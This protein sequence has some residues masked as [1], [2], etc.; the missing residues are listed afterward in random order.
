[1]RP[2]LASEIEACQG[3]PKACVT[4]LKDD[5]HPDG[6]LQVVDLKTSRTESYNLDVCYG[7]TVQSDEIFRNDLEPMLPSLFRGY[8]ATVFT[9][10]ATGSGK[11]Y[12][13]L[14]TPVRPGLMSLAMTS[15][16]GS[17]RKVDC[18]VKISY[19]EV[20][21][22]RCYDLLQSKTEVSVLED[23]SG[24]IQLRGLTQVEVTTVEEFKAKL[25]EGCAR[26]KVGQTGLNDASSRSHGVLM[27][28]V[29]CNSDGT[30]TTG[31]LN[32]IDLAGNEDNR[33]SGNEG[34]R[35][36]ESTKINASLFALSN[37]I[38]ALNANELRVPY[39]DSKLTRILQDSLG[40]TS[41]AVMIACLNPGSYQEASQT[42]SMAARSRQVVNSSSI[43]ADGENDVFEVKEKQNM[44]AKLAAWWETKGKS[45]PAR[46]PHVPSPLRG[47]I[48]CPSPDKSRMALSD[49]SPN[50]RPSF[51]SEVPQCDAKVDKRCDL[52]Q[53][54]AES[55]VENE[56]SRST[57][58]LKVFQD[59]HCGTT[60]QGKHEQTPVREFKGQEA[61][62]E[63]M[64]RNSNDWATPAKLLSNFST[65]P[66]LSTRLRD[67]RN[68]LMS[69]RPLST[70]KPEST[71]CS[72]PNDSL[73]VSSSL[74]YTTDSTMSPT[75]KK[76]PLFSTTP[77][78]DWEMSS[79]GCEDTLLE[80]FLQ[81]LNTACRDE[82]MALKGIGEKRA[83]RLID[84]RKETNEP[85]R[86]LEDL[87]NIGLSVK[88]ARKLFISN[89]TK[90]LEANTA[91]NS[92]I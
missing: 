43:I 70:L 32:I 37:V 34:V 12:T 19:Y 88:Q 73:V 39:R 41:R 15:I 66:P 11:T 80:N 79:R 13:I 90:K 42:L 71:F 69:P 1:M 16:L 9:Y 18:S 10:G 51:K 33:R 91:F 22:D 49:S 57:D 68:S 29:T 48:N 21:M 44:E 61:N 77:M 31:K 36:L 52:A 56:Q 64:D 17:A 25:A 47:K 86:K 55:I 84:L 23:P 54:G 85:I 81:V 78:E 75:I 46:S 2:F 65:S 4:V 50:K 58:I 63:N 76:N 40:G 26:R 92:V 35:L 8:N 74:D 60:A 3:S 83:G 38:N 45:K 72:F 53:C 28:T 67:I 62:K 6:S 20:Y 89:V 30:Q 59:E 7:G 82:L 27:V 24:R 87:E 14:G 5:D